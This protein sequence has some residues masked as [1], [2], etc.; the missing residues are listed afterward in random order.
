MTLATSDYLE[1]YLTLV[2]WI[3]SNG[4]W[5]VLLVSGIFAIPFAFIVIQEWLR[6]RAEGADEGN[7]GVLSS[8]RI[9]NRAWAAVMVILFGCAPFFEVSIA[10]IKFDTSR[11]AQCGTSVPLPDTTKWADAYTTLNGQKAKVPVWWF[12]VHSLSKA[13][14]GAAVAAIP[15]GV[16]LRQMRM[17][18]DATRINDPLLAQELSD[19]ARDCFNPSRAKLLMNRPTLTEE[20]Q[21]DVGW[22]GSK[23][24]LETPGFYDT[25]HA[26]RALDAWPY[27]PVRDAGLAVVTGGGGYPTC[28]EWWLDSSRG[29]RSRLLDQ[30]D[31]ALLSQFTSWAGFMASDKV[32]DSLIR[33]IASPR[34][35][36]MNRGAVY[37]D[38]GGA[39][40]MIPTNMVA[41]AA[42]DVGLAIGT[43][44][45][46]P[47]M[48]TVRMA[49]PMV[50]SF[51]KMALVVCIPIVLLIGTYDLKVLMT[52]TC[53]QFSLFFVTFWFELARW[54]DSTI[55]DALYGLNS[56]HLN[57]NPLMGLYNIHGDMLLNFVMAS[58]FIVMPLLW[59]AALGWAGVKAGGLLD[60]LAK[61]TS[62]AQ[63]AGGRLG[64]YITPK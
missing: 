39:V 23:Y 45:Y 38:Y 24:F 57:F 49:L 17:D 5:E 11:S 53:V 56:P 9:E 14:T 30:V 4:I 7:K 1:Y 50:L 51:L 64:E 33:A 36:V 59:M 34:K 48:D 60:G 19:F 41:R 25:Y 46:F 16:D 6:A 44:V 54:I 10:T 32:A 27:N 40:E 8:L 61:G 21:Y 29:L 42:S 13:V 2:G 12:L 35:Q 55:L 31:V 47:A 18:L 52:V 58:M 63:T 26:S 43:L 28:N 62:G 15:C 37:S 22:F 3:V 20:Q